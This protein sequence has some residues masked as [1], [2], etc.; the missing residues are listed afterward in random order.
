MDRSL[1]IK[2]TVGMVAV[3]MLLITAGLFNLQQLAREGEARNLVVH[4]L[5]VITQLHYIRATVKDA[6]I[7]EQSYVLTGKDQY[8]QLLGE[9]EPRARALVETLRA[10]TKDNPDQQRQ[11]GA[12][13]I[14]VD[15]KFA[16]LKETIAM[17]RSSKHDEAMTLIKADRGKKL[18]DAVRAIIAEMMATEEQLLKLRTATLEDQTKVTRSALVCLILLALILFLLMSRLIMRFVASRQRAVVKLKK[19]EK[20]LADFFDNAVVSLQWVG[21]DGRILRVN[22]AECAMLGYTQEELLGHHIEEFHADKNSIEDILTRLKDREELKN[23]EARLICKDGAIKTV[24]IDSNVHF[25]DGEFIHSRCF[26]RDITLQKKAESELLDREARNRTLVETAPD[27]I[28]TFD[29]EGII[30]STNKAVAAIFGWQES[31]MVGANISRFIP[32]FFSDSKKLG[33][34][35]AISTGQNQIFETGKETVGVNKSGATVP[36]EL[37]WS[38]LNLGSRSV[39]TAIIRDI[40]GRK[41]VERRLAL[42]YE[43]GKILSESK[44]AEIMTRRVLELTGEVMQWSVGGFWLVDKADNVLKCAEVWS[45]SRL[46]DSRFVA[47]TKEVTFAPG[48]GLPGRVWT[49]GQPCYIEDVSEDNNFPRTGAAKIEGV[50]AAMAFPVIAGE[51]VI[52]VFDFFAEDKLAV[53][54]DTQKTMS[55]VGHQIGQFIVRVEAESALKESEERFRL[56]LSNVRDYAI[57]MLDTDGY[58]I[59]WNEGAQR[60]KGYTADEIIGEHVSKFYQ[61]Q[62][63][64]SGKPARVLQ[65][66]SAEGRFE[67]EGWRL[68]K[69]G[70]RFFANVVITPLKDDTG[71]LRGFAKVTR[72]ITDRRAIEEA[73]TASRERYDLAVMGS[74]D[75]I[76]DW[77]LAGEKVFYSEIA[78]Q[79]LGYE[80]GEIDLSNRQALSAM[81]HPDD[82][83]LVLEAVRCHL[84]EKKPYD[85]EYRL[86]TKSGEFKWIHSRG[87]AVWDQAGKSYSFYRFASRH[88]RTHPGSGAHQTERKPLPP[89]G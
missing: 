30:E 18:L 3:L 82:L 78:H 63:I 21:A 6:E 58:V 68:R 11:I 32:G 50:K 7:A 73:L 44:T 60:I 65:A 12:L 5:Q 26:T 24:L 28:L 42:Q 47:R 89:N 53:D 40:G 41:T 10:L 31:E 51:E 88:N 72:D 87:Q 19:S 57:I 66:A 17:L 62:D 14:K 85:I 45:L 33:E 77:D 1:K 83:P 38:V 52:G 81:V 8:L 69:D 20:E 36:I 4:T 29:G 16:E 75:G 86:R 15:D 64:V 13:C 48:V 39:L 37:A 49:S 80:P 2:T 70:S 9:S 54:A 61:P 35:E 59:S 55:A 76:W 27:A 25:E 74:H 56:L 34:M 22:R 79:Q 67:D 71:K 84:N 46:A 23:Y 43:I